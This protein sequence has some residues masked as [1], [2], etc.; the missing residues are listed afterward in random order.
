MA[1]AIG[2]FLGLL[3][4]FGSFL[5]GPFW[6]V[7]AYWVALAWLG[8]AVFGGGAALILRRL[9]SRPLAWVAIALYVAVLS[10][11]FGVV[12]WTL[13]TSLWPRLR[14]VPGL[15]PLVWY[16]EGLTITAP[17]VALFVVMRTRRRKPSGGPPSPAPGLLG[18]APGE[19]LCL[20]MEDHYV[21]VHTARGSSLVLATF[22]QGVA[23]LGGA[24]GLRVHR[25]WWVAE[26]AVAGVVADG[27]NLRLVLTNGLSA[28]VARSSVAAVRQ[29]GWLERGPAA[30]ASD[31]VIA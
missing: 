26:K 27:R 29:A 21:R 8:F 14:H 22:A 13:A 7:V 4:P 10:V 20:Q 17:Q 15:T 19:V 6:Q 24:P 1:T 9:G 30:S 18:V 12:S 25:S 16:L 5:N 11:P 31:S 23:A 28:P 2:G 3:G